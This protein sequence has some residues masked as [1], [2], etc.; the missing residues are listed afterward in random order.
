MSA[1]QIQQRIEQL[2]CLILKQ[3]AV[4]KDQQQQ[5][6]Q[7]QNEMSGHI[8]LMQQQKAEYENQILQMQSRSQQTEAFLQQRQLDQ[9][10]SLQQYALGLNSH[11]VLNL[12]QQI[13][14]FGKGH[15]L[16][17][18]FK[19]VEN[20]LNV[21]GQNRDL[22]NYGTEIIKN[23]KIIG[24]AAKSCQL[25]PEDSC[26]E[27]IKR[28]LIKDFGPRRT[29]SEVFN[30]F[31]YIKISSLRELFNVALECKLEVN[32]IFIHDEQKPELYLPQNVDRD[33]TEIL[34]TKIDG[35]F[36][37]C[38]TEQTPNIESLFKRFS[39]LKLLDDTR[40]INFRHRKIN[41]TQNDKNGKRNECVEG[42]SKYKQNPSSFG[43]KRNSNKFSTNCA[44][45][46]FSPKTNSDIHKNTPIPMDIGNLKNESEYEEVNFLGDHLKRDYP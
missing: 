20:V 34:I 33:L 36:R 12:F 37:T 17:S 45:N 3:E 29:Y 21:C 2:E 16:S 25:L 10:G 11:Q 4:I 14:P 19:S 39:Q 35:Q 27:V 28:Q 18:F 1:E 44:Q 38:F 43:N 13:K 46:T 15:N 8:Q 40:A 32:D 26:W 22:I 23:E 31:R 41:K 42:Q 9:Q 5:Q 6:L 24:N 7:L 30:Y